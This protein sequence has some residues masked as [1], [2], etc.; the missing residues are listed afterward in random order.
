MNF[1]K[2]LKIKFKFSLIF[3]LILIFVFILGIS[4]I[5]GLRYTKNKYD[6]LIVLNNNLINASVTLTQDIYNLRNTLTT[7]LS[8]SKNI[9][10][11]ENF[12]TSFKKCEDSLKE[13][14]NI[15]QTLNKNNIDTTSITE[16]ANNIDSFLQNYKKEIYSLIDNL[17]S[18]NQNSILDSIKKVKQ[19]G[20]EIVNLMYLTPQ[21][22]SEII[23][24]QIKEIESDVN[25]VK[26]LLGFIFIFIMIFGFVYG[27]I[28]SRIIRKPIERLKDI[29]FEMSKGNL[30]IDM[31]SNNKDEIGILCNALSDMSDTFKN[32]L[33]DINTMSLEIQAGNVHHRINTDK[34]HG[35]FKDATLAVNDST[36]H[37][38][39]DSIY[40]LNQIKEF[41]KGNFDEKIKNFPGKKA[42][43]KDE[44][45][46]VQ[47]SLKSVL[48]DIESLIN[49]TNAG[50]LEF[51][52]KTDGYVGKWKETI[53][54][55]NK[56]TENV[57]TPIKEAQ[58][59]LEEFSKGNFAYKMSGDYKGEF[60]NIKQNVNYTSE[61]IGSYISE[62]SHILNEM[63]NK[64]FNL[65]IDRNYLG[66][67]EKIKDSVNLIIT[68]LNALNK[69][70]II[71]AQKVSEG[72]RQ[73]SESSIS[74]A[75]GAMKQTQAVE[76]LNSTMEII[77][78]Q[79]SDNAKNTEKANIIALGAKESASMGNQQMD[80]M[81]LAMEE[82]NIAAN[83]ISNII[84]VIDD[85]AFQTNILALNAAVEAARAGE[86]G[87]GFAVVAEEVRN[88]AGRSQQAA[89]ETTEL[90]KSS[91]EKVAEGSNIANNTASALLSIVNQIEQIANLV[92]SSNLSSKA[93]EQ[94]IKEARL[95]IEEIAK[96][97]ESNNKTSQESAMA[98][99]ELATQSEIFYS[100]VSEFKLKEDE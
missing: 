95:G 6:E 90:I 78:Q 42:I 37:L 4:G 19:Y 43:I 45:L 49:A 52:L 66:D 25:K 75:N 18:K 77:T 30:D 9:N 40:L 82:I 70:I 83:N 72:S 14:K 12:N 80:N 3:G 91:V 57:S 58:K 50:N 69:D 61:T 8:N 65:N 27:L 89:R 92:S 67:F 11:E 13:Y 24:T 98:S 59:A 73:I 44:I 23:S 35:I 32:I 79:S 71:S 84:K 29:A 26:I 28:L 63:A 16:F 93:Q 41:G 33:Y 39:D 36:D 47:N 60:N 20:N 22:S 51:R 81:L 10:I 56:V 85:I 7:D 2:N 68:N 1:I 38:V 87:K 55:L 64:N 94:S 54:G 15:I 74:L 53:D 31:R 86:H 62:I 96:V 100:S 48:H 76:K 21:K 88:L 17:N 99:E 97:T 34:Y 46:S 5:L